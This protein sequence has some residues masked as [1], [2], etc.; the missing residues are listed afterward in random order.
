MDRWGRRY[1][2]HLRALGIRL[3]TLRLPPEQAAR[4]TKILEF[5]RHALSYMTVAH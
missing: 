5:V 3:I 4:Y 2:L 1:C